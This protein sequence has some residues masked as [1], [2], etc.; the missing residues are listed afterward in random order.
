MPRPNNAGTNT[1]P[2]VSATDAATASEAA[3]SG[4]RPSPSRIHS[5]AVPAVMAMPSAP[6]VTTPARRQAT[7]G[8][9]PFGPRAAAAGFCGSGAR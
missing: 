7:I 1:T 5:T 4:T 2:P 3:E 6:Q 9:V 8:I